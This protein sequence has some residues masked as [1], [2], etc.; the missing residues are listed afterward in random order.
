MPNAVYYDI[1]TTVQTQ[2]QALVTAGTLTTFSNANI[3]IRKRPKEKALPDLPGILI[4]PWGAVA[5]PHDAGT[6]ERDD[7][8]YPVL[9][10]VVVEGGK[11]NANNISRNMLWLEVIRKEFIHQLLSGVTSV[12]DCKVDERD[13]YDPS[14]WDDSVELGW[15]IL[16][17]VSRETR[18]N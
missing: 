6:N 15:M 4:C 14:A 13:T 9:I 1:L 10:A 17:F 5:S 3:V 18:G 16:R 8:E 11:D 2:I 7:I 12:I